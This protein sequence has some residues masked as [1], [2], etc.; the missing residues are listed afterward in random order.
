M[1]CIECRANNPDSNRY[2]GQCG[3]ELGRTLDETLRK[4]GFRDRQA[5]EMEIT[6]SVAGRLSKWARWLA[7]IVALV[8]GLF[9]LFL[10]KG[11]ND[12]RTAV[13]EVKDEIITAVE[14]GKQE[15]D[16]V[17]QSIPGLKEQV[18]QLQLD[19]ET[20]VEEGKDEIITAV[21]EGKQEIDRVRQTIPGLEEQVEQ[22][23]L[24]VERYRKVND[25]IGKLQKQITAVQGQVVDL[26]ERTLRARTMETTGPGP[27]SLTFGMLGCPPSEKKGE[28]I[29]C[30]QGS[31]PSLFQVTS[32]G[33]RPVSS[34]SSFG[35]QDVSTSPKPSCTAAKRGTLYVEK[36]ARNVADKPFFCAKKSD[37]TYDWIPFGTTP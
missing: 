6:E 4:K 18:E 35:F 26:G 19:V 34:F 10:G 37:N 28:V 20:A 14:K 16:Q 1:N 21:R 12:F 30:A 23:Q 2:C 29:Y 7:I 22:V 13:G 11:Y 25:D 24:D 8:V 5:T 15:I 17:R 36:G 9:F 31:P 32:T 27:S 3:A 33:E